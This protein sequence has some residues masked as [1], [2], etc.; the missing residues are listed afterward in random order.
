MPQL[1]KPKLRTHAPQQETWL[2]WEA[3]C[4][5]Q[6]EKACGQQ[7]R[8]R[9]AKTKFF[10]RRTL[11]AYSWSSR[12]WDC[13][14][15]HSWRRRPGWW[16]AVSP[17][18]GY[19]CW[20]YTWP[21]LR[22]ECN[23]DKR[24]PPW[25]PPCGSPPAQPSGSTLTPAAEPQPGKSTENIT[26]SSPWPW[27][28]KFLDDF[29]P[30]GHCSDC[31]SAIPTSDLVP[32]FPFP[33]GRQDGASSLSSPWHWKESHASLD[34]SELGWF[35]LTLHLLISPSL[36]PALLF[37]TPHPGCGHFWVFCVLEHIPTLPSHLEPCDPFLPDPHKSHSQ[38]WGPPAA[39][40]RRSR[41]GREAQCSRRWR[42][43]K[44]STRCNI[45][46]PRCTS[47]DHRNTAGP[48][49]GICKGPSTC[50]LW[51]SQ[52]ELVEWELRFLGCVLCLE[53]RV[54]SGRR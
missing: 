6:L 22:R 4:P 41:W 27:S 13:R 47:R 15:K 14:H 16:Q 9:T 46:C 39:E 48:Q 34:T 11:P 36:L 8:P 17:R 49:G 52:Q 23:R 20:L 30:G 45:W 53:P 54:T 2:Q 7:Q 21:G 1:L 35:H 38:L 43:T 5:P 50:S 37:D 31:L 12:W 29:Q 40:S 18:R 24:I 33:W 19:G 26:P 25:P 42:G 51:G 44:Y 3:P 28:P 10:K 32:L